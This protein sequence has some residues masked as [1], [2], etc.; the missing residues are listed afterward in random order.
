[1]IG[2]HEKAGDVLNRLLGGA[3]ADAL[4]SPPGEHVKPL[5]G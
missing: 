3:Q 4:Q 5:Q 1:L 2:A